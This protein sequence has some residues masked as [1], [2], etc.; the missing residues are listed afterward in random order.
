MVTAGLKC[1]P[2]TCPTA[3]AMVSTVRPNAR[4]TP[5]K[6]MPSWIPWPVTT[7]GAR[8][9]AAKMAL[10]QPPKTSQ[11]VP[12]ASAPSREVNA[13]VRMRSSPLVDNKWAHPAPAGTTLPQPKAFA[14][15]DTRRRAAR[16]V[17]TEGTRA[18]SAHP[19]E[20]WP[21]NRADDAKRTA[22]SRDLPGATRSR[23]YLRGR[24]TAGGLQGAAAVIRRTSDRRCA[25]HHEAAVYFGSRDAE[26]D[27]GRVP[28]RSSS[29]WATRL[30]TAE[31]TAA[32]GSSPSGGGAELGHEVLGQHADLGPAL[33]AVEQ[34][35]SP[36]RR[37]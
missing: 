4:A 10:P 5:R 34:R 19:S 21:Q 18:A 9:L 24:V 27:G 14:H 15:C 3:Y 29:A 1:A 37:A 31:S 32:P 2:E 12:S 6:P 25:R 35:A 22:G 13:G 16:R 28:S 23:P 7:L 11:K 36:A 20:G 30:S 17:S 33:A 8:N 26:V